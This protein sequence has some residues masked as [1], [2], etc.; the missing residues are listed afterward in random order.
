[1]AITH[2]RIEPGCIRCSACA[3][4]APLVFEL[5]NDTDATVRVCARAE[6]CANDAGE[7]T[8]ASRDGDQD[9]R[10]REAADGC[11]VSIIHYR[12]RPED[13]AAVP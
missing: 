4:A 13:S 7:Y 5:A 3:F 1:M 2:V 12:E 10:I 8:L 6:S 9:E 11:P